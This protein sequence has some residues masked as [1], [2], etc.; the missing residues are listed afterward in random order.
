MGNGAKYSIAR[1]GA[2]VDEQHVH[3]EEEEETGE[4]RQVKDFS[5]KKKI[6]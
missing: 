2:S 5:G 6:S 3:V 1:V 4:N